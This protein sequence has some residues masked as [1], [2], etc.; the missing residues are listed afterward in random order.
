MGRINFRVGMNKICRVSMRHILLSL[1]KNTQMFFRQLLYNFDGNWQDLYVWTILLCLCVSCL[2][3]LFHAFA[4][5]TWALEGGD[6][7]T[8][9]VQEKKTK[10]RQPFCWIFPSVLFCTISP[11]VLPHGC[12]SFLNL[13]VYANLFLQEPTLLW[14]HIACLMLFWTFH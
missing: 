13:S 1:T 4:A 5:A 8:V 11:S 14:E 7:V 6:G 9:C 3:W 12:C 10:I 2:I